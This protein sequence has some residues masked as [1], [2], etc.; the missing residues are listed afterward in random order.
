VDCNF[1]QW[2]WE[3]VVWATAIGPDGR[4]RFTGLLNHD[5]LGKKAAP[6]KGPKPLGLKPRDVKPRT[7]PQ[8]RAG[9]SPDQAGFKYGGGGSWLG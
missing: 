3:A 9:D 8:N 1:H 5:E 4:A 6:G 2:S 7:V